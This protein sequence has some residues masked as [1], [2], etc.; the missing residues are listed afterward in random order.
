VDI[1]ICGMTLAD[2]LEKRRWNPLARLPS[3]EVSGIIM[4]SW[5]VVLDVRCHQER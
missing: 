4:K 3:I 5:P 1:Y 2:A